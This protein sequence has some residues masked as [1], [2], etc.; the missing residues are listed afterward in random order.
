MKLED[1]EMQIVQSADEAKKI[2]LK[3][4]W[5]F[6]SKLSEKDLTKITNYI[7]KSTKHHKPIYKISVRESGL[8]PAVVWPKKNTLY[9]N[10]IWGVL[11][12]PIGLKSKYISFNNPILYPCDVKLD[13]KMFENKSKAEIYKMYRQIYLSAGRDPNRAAVSSS[14]P[15]DAK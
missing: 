10:F 4:N 12:K 6:F 7:V 3:D 11:I 14:P 15:Q 1:I 8:Y 13:I 9:H 2:L 5:D